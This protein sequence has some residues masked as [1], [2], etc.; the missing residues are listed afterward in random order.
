MNTS[1]DYTYQC[2]VVDGKI[3]N[4]GHPE[5]MACGCFGRIWAGRE[6][7]EIVKAIKEAR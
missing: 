7:K 6:H 5:S 2:W 1:F 3:Q 4:C